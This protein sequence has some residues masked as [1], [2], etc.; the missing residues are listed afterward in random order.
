ML[1]DQQNRQAGLAALKEKDAAALLGVSPKTMQ[2]W[3]W[4][5]RGPDYLKMGEGRGSA[6]RYEPEALEKFKALS[7]I[8]A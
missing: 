2:Q 5:G 4:L 8:K 6:I 3:R 1:T 7:R